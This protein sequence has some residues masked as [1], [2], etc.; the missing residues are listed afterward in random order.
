MHIYLPVGA[1][2]INVGW[3]VCAGVGVGIVQGLLGS[4]GFLLTPILIMLGV[5]PAV[6]A[7]SG[8]NAI[9]GASVSGSLAHLKAGNVD[10]K[11]GLLILAG[12]V[13][14]GALGTRIVQLLRAVGNLDLV[15][16]SCYVVLM[17]V[18][19]VMVFVEGLTSQVQGEPKRDRNSA[20]QK[21]L[22]KLPLQM[23]FAVSGTQTSALAPFVL[24]AFVG[25]LAAIM[26][27]GGGFILIPAMAY[28][29]DMPMRVVVGTSLFQMLFTTSSVTLMQAAVNHTV[30][31]VLASILLIGSTLGAQLGAR[32]AQRLRADQL[33]V[34]FSLMVLAMSLKM[35]NGLLVA[36]PFLLKRLLGR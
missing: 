8:I 33:K 12:G 7:A 2:D 31:V 14:G 18:I 35:L 6:S 1:M 10:V 15:I 9:A 36:P 20:V 32:A 19:G 30:D 23:S 24:G 5:S 22:R 11:M 25:V 26:G 28:L 27:V 21:V 3:L 13:S 17:A 29:L 16:L 4:G 34:V